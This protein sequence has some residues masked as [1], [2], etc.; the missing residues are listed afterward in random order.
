VTSQNT[1]KL[2][3]FFFAKNKKNFPKKGKLWIF[4][5]KNGK[6]RGYLIDHQI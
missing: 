1:G 2:Q 4:F 5:A 3:E 6:S